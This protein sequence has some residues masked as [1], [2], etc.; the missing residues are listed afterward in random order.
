[1][2]TGGD[3]SAVIEY[4]MR[5]E[6]LFSGDV[7]SNAAW[8]REIISTSKGVFKSAKYDEQYQLLSL[9]V[10]HEHTDDDFLQKQFGVTP[11]F[12]KRAREHV[13]NGGTFLPLKRKRPEPHTRKSSDVVQ[14]LAE[15]LTSPEDF[16]RSSYRSAEVE[17][18][19]PVTTFFDQN[20]L[21]ILKKVGFTCALVT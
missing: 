7:V 8:F 17:K 19:N 2:K 18:N 21:G 11:Y 9:F 6:K 10:G 14:H 3:T 16:E 5:R 12:L 15:F 1:M 4:L 13:N 20:Q